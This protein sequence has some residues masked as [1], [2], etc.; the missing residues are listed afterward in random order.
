MTTSSEWATR[1]SEWRSRFREWLTRLRNAIRPDRTDRDLEEELRL[2]VQ[3][4]TEDER[5]RAASADSA[6]R[7]E[8]TAAI[9][10][11]AIPQTMERLRDQRGLPWF[12]DFVR[13][14][15]HALRLLR[16]SPVFTIAS[17]LSLAVG[18]GA[19]SAIFSM[20]DALILRPPAVRDPAAVVTIDVE[21]PGQ[22]SK[23]ISYPN[24]LDLATASQS[25]EGLV[26]REY[27]S[28]SFA[29]SRDDLREVRRGMLVSDFA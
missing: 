12:D 16:R 3:L 2:H 4:A 25:F 6:D 29:R 8:R 9:R 21:T 5:R 18:V 11:G 24:Y 10:V 15:R 26:A 14:V 22:L 7:A 28:A 20:A 1:V 27:S 19:N 17:V 23:R 13:D